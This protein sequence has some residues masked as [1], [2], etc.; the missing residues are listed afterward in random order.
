MRIDATQIKARRLELDWTQKELAEA[1]S[2]HLSIIKAVETGRSTDKSNLLRIAEA[3]ELSPEAVF[4]ENYRA[5]RVLSVI[6]NKGGSGKTSLAGSLGFALAE[7]GHRVLLIDADAQRNLTSSFG[8][9]KRDKHFGHAVTQEADLMEEGYIQPSGYEN[10]DFVVADASMGT[11][12]MVLFT[13][14]HREN[15]VKQVLTPLI[16]NGIYDFVIIDTNPNLSLLNFNIVNASNYALIPVQMASFDVEGIGTVV[17]FIEGIQRFNSG[18]SILGIVINRYDKRTKIIT[19]A[20]EEELRRT[21][22][23]LIFETTIRI[24]TKIQ[25]AQWENKP[26]FLLGSSR[27]ASEYRE[28][29]KEVLRRC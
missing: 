11:L 25:N 8:Q 2:V 27:I 19:A 9:S 1:A 16:Q 14:M 26:V 23:S 24:D 7:M 20:A 4:N 28:L 15:V 17:A 3:L 21:Y 13:K 10:I 12:D 6:N 29:A 22:G 18:L 5:T